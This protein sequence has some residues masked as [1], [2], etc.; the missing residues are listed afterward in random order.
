MSNQSKSKFKSK[1]GENEEK[2]QLKSQLARA[3]A[4]YDNL[5]KR[6]D[7]EKA[8]WIQFSSQALLERLLPALDMLERAQLHLKDK[9]LELAITEFKKTLEEEGLSEIK[10]A[11]GDEFDPELMEVVEVVQGKDNNIVSE[12]I[13]A[14]WRYKDGSVIRHAKV[15]VTSGP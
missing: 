14:G 12:L 15:K 2:A 1:N 5:V 13:S 4:D 7:E 10:P 11:P 6:T 9:G 8:K 3:L